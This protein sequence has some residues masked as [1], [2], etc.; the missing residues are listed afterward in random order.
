MCGLKESGHPLPTES[1][2]DTPF[3]QPPGEDTRSSWMTPSLSLLMGRGLAGCRR[4][5]RAQLWIQGPALWIMSHGQ[6]PLSVFIC[7]MGVLIYP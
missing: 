4:G 3:R 5:Q 7:E 2:P 6:T 1:E